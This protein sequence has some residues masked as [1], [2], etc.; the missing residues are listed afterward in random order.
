MTTTTPTTGPRALLPQLFSAIHVE[1]DERI[2]VCH[3][4][5][6]RF[7]ATHGTAADAGA[8]AA[9]YAGR[10]NCWHSTAAL[11]RDIPL[12]RRGTRDHVAR[13]AA[14]FTDL[15]VGGTGRCLPDWAAARG[16]V[17]AL[18]N[19]LG[20]PA[21][22]I[23][24]TGGGAHPYW[25]ISGGD[26]VDRAEAVLARFGVLVE[27]LCAEAGGA[28]DHVHEVARVLRTPG[29][30]NL[31]EPG[32]PRP[33]ELRLRSAVT[34]ISLA[35][36]ERIL[37][38]VPAVG[39]GHRGD[40][41]AGRAG[42]DLLPGQGDLDRHGATRQTAGDPYRRLQGLVQ[43][44]MDSRPGGRNNALNWAAHTA[45][46]LTTAYPVDKI[47]EALIAAGVHAGLSP[48][49]ARATVASGLGVRL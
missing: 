27:A 7:T 12:G 24:L 18:D 30:V 20:V 23:V 35:H 9:G 15:D 8:R 1:P 40:L 34:P 21:P 16:V 33:V 47:A 39:V 26:D 46:D 3:D 14:L 10:A 11:V 13:V 29:T 48:A 36:L 41:H 32:N 31:K 4:L 38:E 44:V 17:A 19:A 42:H 37:P 49:E 45:R 28:V 6:G 43:S 22:A 5:G 25:P 2:S